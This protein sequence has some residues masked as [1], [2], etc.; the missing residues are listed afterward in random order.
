VIRRIA[1]SVDEENEPIDGNAGTES[2]GEEPAA[3]VVDISPED[4]LDSCPSF[5]VDERETESPA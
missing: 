2:G 5:L 1:A 4:V 3:E